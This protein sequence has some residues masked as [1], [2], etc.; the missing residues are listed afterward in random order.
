MPIAAVPKRMSVFRRNGLM[1]EGF[2]GDASGVCFDSGSDM[3]GR[4]AGFVHGA[5]PG[6]YPTESAIARLKCREGLEQI[7]FAELRPEP[8][9]EVELRVGRAPEQEV[10]D[11]LL[12]TGAD[13]KVDRADVHRGKR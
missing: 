6:R 13:E 2:S 3:R 4:R 8:V 5:G 7:A 12:S 10:G 1:P 9:G 11:P